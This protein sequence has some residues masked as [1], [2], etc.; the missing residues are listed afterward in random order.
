MIGAGDLEGLGNGSAAWEC[1][2]RVEG[3]FGR[4][5]REGW[6]HEAGETFSFAFLIFCGAGRSKVGR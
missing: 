2:E 1:D 5:I 4:W 6:R 3:Y